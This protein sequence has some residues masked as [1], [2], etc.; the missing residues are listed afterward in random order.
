MYRVMFGITGL[1]GTLSGNGKLFDKFTRKV[2]Q[3]M[4]DFLKKKSAP[5]V[6]FF[7]PPFSAM[8]DNY[9]F[10]SDQPSKRLC[11]VLPAARTGMLV[12]PDFDIG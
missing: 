5:W 11:H 2:S 10:S 9:R 7:F 12:I 1:G 8:M 3:E 6:L 4:N